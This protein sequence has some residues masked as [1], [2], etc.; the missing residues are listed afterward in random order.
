MAK[1]LVVDDD[2]TARATV[3]GGIELAG[4]TTIQA[5]D[6]ERAYAILEDNPDVG[7]VVTDVLMPRMD[8]RELVR[9][10]RGQPALHIGP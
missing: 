8:G 1:V 3:A 2:R 4:H 7:M 6:G 10:L 5:A 9:I